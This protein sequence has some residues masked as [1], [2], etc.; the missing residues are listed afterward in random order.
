M[1]FDKQ[2]I[3]HKWTKRQQLSLIGPHFLL[4]FIVLSTLI[5]LIFT[6]NYDHNWGGDFSA[7]IMQAKSICEF[8]TTQFIENNRITI[9]QSSRQIGPIAYPWGFPLMLAPIYYFF[10]LNFFALKILG[11]LFYIILLVILWYG[12]E[13]F[14]SL[15]WRSIYLFLFAVNPTLVGFTNNVLSDIP[16]LCF[17]TITICLISFIIVEQRILWTPIKD[18]ILLGTI[19]ACS[20]FVRT[21]GILLIFVL[22]WSQLAN[23]CVLLW[24]NYKHEMVWRDIFIIF[25]KRGLMEQNNKI[26]LFVPYIV[27]SC[28]IIIWRLILPSG[29]SSHFEHLSHIN[30][31]S[32]K[33]NSIYYS[34]L[35]ADFFTGIPDFGKYSGKQ[36]TYILTLP[37]VAI[38]I[39]KNIRNSHHVLV[40]IFLTYLL[41]IL[42]PHK[43]G[44]RF[45]FPVLP[46][47]LFFL[48]SG[49][50]SVINR[51]NLWGRITT[52]ILCL[53]SIT[54]ISFQFVTI[55]ISQARAKPKSGNV[56]VD[57][58]MSDTS[59]EMFN[60]IRQNT[61]LQ[62]TIVFFKPRV[63][64]L[65]T[66]RNTLGIDS[67]DDIFVADY[68]C[69]YKKIYPF[70]IELMQS[71]NQKKTA[72]IKFSNKHYTI[73][74]LQQTVSEIISED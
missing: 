15:V 52:Q 64:R 5:I 71:T 11:A 59:L 55:S 38:G 7:Y 35:L 19:I 6:L 8:T 24:K 18:R 10:G 29:G 2:T 37:L 47:Y 4:F 63:M 17:S 28:L 16:F 74:K 1:S 13:Q 50:S 48:M 30:T 33:G 53:F 42:W 70:H 44:L 23:T 41:F 60:F 34:S 26:L 56:R 62:D 68:I 20:F 54:F 57:G 39:V 58:L 12:F 69:F 61:T 51:K 3:T 49:L 31:E 21:N 40:Y 72:E 65:M 36:V 67:V 66:E 46:F 27:F 25:W 32:I 45:L 73:Y 43:Q 14:E 9:E 22:C